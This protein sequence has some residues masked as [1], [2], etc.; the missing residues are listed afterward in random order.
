MTHNIKDLFNKNYSEAME[1]KEA[2]NDELLDCINGLPVGENDLELLTWL[3]QEDDLN[4]EE[5]EISLYLCD[6][7]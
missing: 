1:A 3:G 6:P 4:D 7:A 5:Q 2:E